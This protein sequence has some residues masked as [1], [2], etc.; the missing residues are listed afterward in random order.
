MT[1]RMTRIELMLQEL[2]KRFGE[3]KTDNGEGKVEP[4]FVDSES[5]F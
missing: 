1:D 2:D 3:L 4:L 5:I